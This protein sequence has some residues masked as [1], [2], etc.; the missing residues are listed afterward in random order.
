MDK[1]TELGNNF[2]MLER[3]INS[4]INSPTIEGRFLSL[5][6]AKETV[7]KIKS[8]LGWYTPFAIKK[9]LCAGSVT[10]YGNTY[11]RKSKSSSLNRIGASEDWEEW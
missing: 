10:I 8:I 3:A 1:K 9:F 5:T 6:T 7:A 4:T 2:L 11:Y